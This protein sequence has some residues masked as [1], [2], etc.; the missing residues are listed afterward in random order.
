MQTKE[1]LAQIMTLL[2]GQDIKADSNVSMDN[3][4]IW[5]SMKHIEIISTIE[6]EFDI[7]LPIEDIPKLTSFQLLAEAVEK[8]L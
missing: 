8:C 2:L 5:D 1:K 7:S 4:E 3:C 6:E